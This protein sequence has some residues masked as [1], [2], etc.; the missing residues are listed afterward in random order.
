MIRDDGYAMFLFASTATM[1]DISVPLD[2]APG[3]ISLH[4]LD[5]HLQ[6]AETSSRMEFCPYTRDGLWAFIEMTPDTANPQRKSRR[7]YS[8]KSTVGDTTAGDYGG[9]SISLAVAYEFDRL[10]ND[11]TN[12][13]I[14]RYPGHSNL[15]LFNTPEGG[16]GIMLIT[17][18]LGAN[19]YEEHRLSV[20]HLLDVQRLAESVNEARWS[21]YCRYHFDFALGRLYVLLPETD[22]MPGML[23]VIQY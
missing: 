20:G 1:Y 11:R 23:H 19:A 4:P 10:H 16:A 22:E 5:V 3:I 21:T 6:L 12:T 8:L 7:A 15:L 17:F 9:L 13:V 14:S 2:A 18:D